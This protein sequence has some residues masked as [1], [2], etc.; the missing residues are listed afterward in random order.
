MICSVVVFGFNVR[1]NIRVSITTNGANLDWNIKT[2]VS[3][4]MGNLLLGSIF[5]FSSLKQLLEYFWP[6]K[7]TIVY[8]G[9][10]LLL[11]NGLLIAY[12]M[13]GVC[14]SSFGTTCVYSLW[15]NTV[16]KLKLVDNPEAREGCIWIISRFLVI[17]AQNLG[18]ASS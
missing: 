4:C 6:C 10:F 18:N 13:M 11:L 17:K 7:M 1:I 16:S 15:K 9:G 8:M 2:C 3:L 5:I 14:V 12:P